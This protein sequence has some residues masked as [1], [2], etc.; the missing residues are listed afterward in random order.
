MHGALTVLLLALAASPAHADDPP[1]EAEE[2][3]E[4]PLLDLAALSFR[5]RESYPRLRAAQHRIVAAQ[6]QLDEAIISPF[7]QFHA[8]VGLTVAPEVR[9]TPYFSPDNQFP[10]TNAWRPVVVV[11]ASGLVPLYTFGKLDA[12]RRAAR[13]G[14]TAA[15]NERGV[16]LARLQYDVRRAYYGLQLSLDVQQMIAEGQTRLEQAATQLEEML[17]AG[18]SNVSESDRYR[19]ATAISEVDARLSEAVRL[20]RTTRAALRA[21]TGVDRFRV[22]QCPIAPLELPVRRLPHYR[23]LALES[24]PEV[25]MLRAGIEAR[26]ANVDATRARFYP[27]IALTATASYSYGPGIVDQTNPFIIDQANYQALGAGIVARWSFDVWGNLHRVRRAEA[28]LSELEALAEEAE[29]GIELEVADAYEAL[30]DARRREEAWREGHRQSRRWF[31]SAAGAYSVG[32]LEPRDLID[33]VRAYFTARFN[34]LAAISDV[35]IGIANLARVIGVELLPVGG[36]EV[37]CE[38]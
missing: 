1:A 5:A 2:E 8:T 24:R 38:E 9:G 22:P 12:A 19:L 14:I 34:H 13:A 30:A 20:E 17:A 3:R 25:R 28:E 36:W 37:G 27:D 10:V 6:A 16:T 26:T 29:R 35:N 15:E 23:S 18:D 32:A 4:P 7:F 33:A 11:G 31:I 21:L